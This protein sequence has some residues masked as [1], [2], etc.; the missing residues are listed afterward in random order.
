MPI[1][2]EMPVDSR[3]ALAFPELPSHSGND[4]FLQLPSTYA[5]IRLI[6]NKKTEYNL[7][8]KKSKFAMST[9]VKSR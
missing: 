4:G 7:Y 5:H 9:F 6:A 3:N 2:A 8:Y 1:K